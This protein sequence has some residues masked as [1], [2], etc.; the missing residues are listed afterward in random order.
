MN[1]LL[2]FMIFM[3]S[4]IYGL[5]VFFTG[6][7]VKTVD[8]LDVLALRFLMSFV[9]LYILKSLKVIRIETGIRDLAKKKEEKE[10]VKALLLAGIFEP[11]LYMFFE[12]MGISMTTGITA[13]V[14]LAVSPV[15][16]CINEAIFLKEKST[17][18]QKIF[19]GIGMAGVMYIAV[20][21]NTDDGQNT[22]SGIV[23]MFLAVISGT[24]YSVFSRKSSK[25]FQAFEVTYITCF[26]GTVVFNLIN[27]VR[28]LLDGDVLRYFAPY[29]SFE[30]LIGFAYLSI[31]STIVATA[32]NNYALSRVHVSTVAA[33]GGVS[34]LVTIAAGIFL[35]HEKLYGFQVIGILLIIIRMVGVSYIDIQKQKQ[36]V[37]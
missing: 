6:T 13:G 15:F 2:A 10:Y 12:T 7:L 11:V 3:K 21:T 37:K 23:F 26:L 28:H 34:T 36:S 5:S 22:V 16:S 4:V 35:N 14:I 1:L 32:M 27:V 20:M 19:L 17:L 30:N 25:H 33:F 31:L 24:L 9:V 8:V 29:M 18:M